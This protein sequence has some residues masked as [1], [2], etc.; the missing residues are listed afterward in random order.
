MELLFSVISI[1]AYFF[2][3]PTVAG[4]VGIVATILFILLY[5]KLEK[6]YTAFVPWLVISVLLNVLFIN[7]K[8]NFVLSIGIVSSMSIWL[9]SVLVWI[10]HSITNK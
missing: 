9:T 2:G 8:P 1:V 4:V 10:F 6:S 3:Y 7:Y 5:S